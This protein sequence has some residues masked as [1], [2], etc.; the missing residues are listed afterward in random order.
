MTRCFEGAAVIITGAGGG[1]RAAAERF[2]AEG[3]SL[4]LGDRDEAGL[5]AAA[6]ACGP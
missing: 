6:H 2:A 5:D 1:R 4:V 3:A